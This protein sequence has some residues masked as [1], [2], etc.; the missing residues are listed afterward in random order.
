VADETERA[1]GAGIKAGWN[2]DAAATVPSGFFFSGAPSLLCLQLTGP[3][4]DFRDF[5]APIESTRMYR[6]G[7]VV[8]SICAQ[9]IVG[10]QCTQSR[11]T[12][13]SINRR[14]ANNRRE[15]RGK[16]RQDRVPVLCVLSSTP[17]TRHHT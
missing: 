17:Y 12:P 15:E 6:Y 16:P 11:L 8:K 10:M 4:A 2:S 13:T 5:Q 1:K 9:I 3:L 14:H 7:Y